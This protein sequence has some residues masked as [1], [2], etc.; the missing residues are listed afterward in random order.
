MREEE[1]ELANVHM[2]AG[3]SSRLDAN[4]DG[5]LSMDDL[6]VK[7]KIRS[8]EGVRHSAQNGSGESG[9]LNYGSGQ[10]VHQA[11]LEDLD[12]LAEAAGFER[13]PWKH[14]EVSDLGDGQVHT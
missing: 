10:S 5:V 12:A 14:W 1:R 13:L 3:T 2:A 8:K 7:L 6:L 11:A 4:G 9:Q